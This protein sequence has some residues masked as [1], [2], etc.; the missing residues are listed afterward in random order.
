VKA[1]SGRQ[2]WWWAILHAGKRIEN[3]H[4]CS[5]ATTQLR[6]YRDSFLLHASKGV[7]PAGEFEHACV[8]ITELLSDAT[9]A[10]MA[11]EVMTIESKTPPRIGPSPHLLRGGII[12]RARV[13]G[14]IDEHGDP[15]DL[16]SVDALERYQPDLRWHIK[17]QIGHILAEV[18]PLP[19]IPCEGALGL[20]TVPEALYRSV[21]SLV[22]R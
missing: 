7:G 6:T 5:S 19:F 22:L 9:L 10:Q 21:S 3:R 13:V 8:A 17:G 16:E 14:R 1:L 11:H 20:W 12:G 15:M 2:P 4:R 18:A